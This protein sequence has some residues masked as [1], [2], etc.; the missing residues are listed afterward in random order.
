MALR[1][2]LWVDRTDLRKTKIVKEST[3]P[4]NEG[5][6]LVAIDEFGLTANNVSYAVSGATI[7]YW[8]F[9]PA[10]DNWGKV[11]VWGCANIIESRCDE[12]KVGER[13]W[14]F[15]PMASHAT[16]QPGKIRDDQFGDVAPHREG[17][18]GPD[19]YSTYRRTQTEPEIVQQY[20]N[21][22]CCLFPLFA[23]SFVIY[24]Y[25]L[26]NK[27]FGAKQVVVGSA[28][29]KTGFGLA[30]MLHDDA[31][32]SQKIVG[33]TSTPNKAFVDSLKCCDQVVVYGDEAQID[34]TIPTAYVDMSGDIKLT[35]TLHNHLQNNMVES[36]MVGASHWEEGGKSVPLPG[37]K[38]KFFFAPTQIAKREKEWGPGETIKKAMEASFAVSSKVRDIMSVEWSEGAE[39]VNESWQNLLDNKIAGSTGIMAT[40]LAKEKQH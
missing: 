8:K 39:A 28:S 2:E 16:L 14:G 13:L 22:R 4:L 21:E 29:S 12:I 20:E 24:D 9:Y 23:T 34:N 3:S 7:G 38:P 17:L 5:E 11:T 33:V 15:F 6:I 1:T 36:A 31:A 32:V 40:L 25:L 26:Y 19:L 18:P 27:F 10:P 35:S 37:A 30:I